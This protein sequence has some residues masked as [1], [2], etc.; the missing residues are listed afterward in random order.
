MSQVDDL[1]TRLEDLSVEPNGL[2]VTDG[3][4]RLVSNDRLGHEHNTTL[5]GMDEV[6]DSLREVRNLLISIY[7]LTDA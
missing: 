3:G 6:L 2:Q 5:E 1:I 7:S 4:D